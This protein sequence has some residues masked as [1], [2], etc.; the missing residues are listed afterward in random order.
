MWGKDCLRDCECRDIDTECDVTTGCAECPDG[1]QGGDCREDIDECTVNNP[2]D[3]HANC[4]NTIG[5]FKCVCHAGYT[6]YNATVCEGTVPSGYELYSQL[7]R[8]NSNYAKSFQQCGKDS[9]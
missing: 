6:Q 4:N 8:C 9:Q 5:T 1:F 2:C 7:W 3:E